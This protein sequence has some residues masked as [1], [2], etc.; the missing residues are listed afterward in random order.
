MAD[1][2]FKKARLSYSERRNIE[3]GHPAH[4]NGIPSRKARFISA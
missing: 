2:C 4:L 3:R 1:R